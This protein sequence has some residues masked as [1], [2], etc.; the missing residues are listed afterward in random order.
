MFFNLEESVENLSEK[1]LS[2][3]L[4]LRFN[5]A[6]LDIESIQEQPISRYLVSIDADF[7]G[8]LSDEYY[9]A[10]KDETEEV[11]S[12]VVNKYLKLFGLNDKT[13]KYCKLI[14][15]IKLSTK[16]MLPESAVDKKYDFNLLNQCGL[17]DN[18]DHIIVTNWKAKLTD[19]LK[20][21]IIMNKE[22]VKTNKALFK[23]QEAS[24]IAIIPDEDC[25]LFFSNACCCRCTKKD[26]SGNTCCGGEY[27]VNNHGCCEDFHGFK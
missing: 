14:T 1:I 12:P 26:D 3:E 11:L 6:S 5:L 7:A 2:G 25:R 13:E 4:F 10:S 24:K 17:A 18:P 19:L 22:K 9:Q 16:Y 8:S 21:M 23:S 27:V 20:E 15:S